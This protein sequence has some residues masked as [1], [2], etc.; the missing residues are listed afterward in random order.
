MSIRTSP[1]PASVP[2]WA[3]LTVPDVTAGKDF[4]A[5]VLGWSYADTGDEFGGYS[6]AQVDGAAAAGIGPLPDGGAPAWT[7]YFASDDADTTAAAV[8]EHG[9]NVLLPPGEVG[10]LGRMFIAA[11]PTGAVFGVW[12]ALSHIGAGIANQPGGLTWDDLRSPDPDA[13]RAF[14]TAVFGFQT[15]MLPDAGPDYATY[16]L[17]GEDKPLGGMGGMMGAEGVPAHWVVY[18]AVADAAAAV[19]AAEESGGSVMMRDFDS[20]YGRMAGLVDPCGA[21]FWVIETDGS[22]QPDRSG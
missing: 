16:S 20:P 9:G 18:F 14:Y 19:T 15:E 1:W 8:T 2:C 4:Y 12:Q 6:I 13:A 17:A 3:D 11:D 5:A 22:D 21:P 7:L 10:E